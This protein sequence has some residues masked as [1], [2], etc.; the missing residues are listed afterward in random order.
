MTNLEKARALLQCAHDLILADLE[1]NEDYQ[2]EDKPPLRRIAAVVSVADNNL[3]PYAPDMGEPM[4]DA[5]VT[6]HV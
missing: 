6:D 5:D 2:E 4:E 1:K 3:Y